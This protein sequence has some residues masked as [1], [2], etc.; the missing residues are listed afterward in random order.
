MYRSEARLVEDLIAANMELA[1]LA[2]AGDVA[3]Y[4]RARDMVVVCGHGTL[5]IEDAAGE[6]TGHPITG[7]E[8]PASIGNAETGS[9]AGEGETSGAASTMS[10]EQAPAL[11]SPFRNSREFEKGQVARNPIRSCG[12]PR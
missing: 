3:A 10:V 4:L 2:D 12:E 11:R 5:V 8:L 6:P 7:P 9:P 1:G